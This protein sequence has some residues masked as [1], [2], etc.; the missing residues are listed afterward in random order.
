MRILPE[1]AKPPTASFRARKGLA[2]SDPLDP[3]PLNLDVVVDQYQIR[4]VARRDTPKFIPQAEKLRRIFAG[5]ASGRDQAESQRGN[6]VTHCVRHVERSAG[7]RA[8]FVPAYPIDDAN[9][10]PLQHES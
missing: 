5:H 8:V 2:V 7:E 9:R 10:A 4:A 1:G 6:R 3:R